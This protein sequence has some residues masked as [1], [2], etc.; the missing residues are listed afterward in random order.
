MA[1]NSA[2]SWTDHTFNPWIGCTAVS[3][4]CANCYAR[5]LMEIRYKRATWGPGEARARTG[6]ANWHNPIR[7]QRQAAATGTRPFVFCSSLA[8]VFDNEVDPAWRADLFELI[9]NTPDLVWLL[10]TK[11]VGNVYRMVRDAGGMKPNI[12]FGATMATQAEYDRDKMKLVAL[13]DLGPLFT[14]GSFEPLLES[15]RIDHCAPDWIIVGGES[16]A[17]F[18]DMPMQWARAL[19]ADAAR[20]N[21]VFHFKQTGGRGGGSHEIDGRTVQARPVVAQR[22]TKAEAV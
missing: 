12:A 6:A 17:K 4:A 3:D 22:R 13:K 16:G 5:D 19:E 10:L 15:V 9:G 2:I 14:F 11:R 18:R 8:D 1:E 7:W 21:R 20:Y